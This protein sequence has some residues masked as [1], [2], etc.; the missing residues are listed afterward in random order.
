MDADQKMLVFTTVLFTQGV[1]MSQI[2][3]AY[4]RLRDVKSDKELCKFNLQ[5]LANARAC[6][7]CKIF[8]GKHNPN[9]WFLQTLGTA[10]PCSSSQTDIKDIKGEIEKLAAEP[11]KESENTE[12]RNDKDASEWNEEDGTIF[13][14]EKVIFVVDQQY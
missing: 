2:K 11:T 10:V 4:V 5:N 6:A 1:T 8:R 12:S 13:D 7:V 3:N 14:L 9:Q